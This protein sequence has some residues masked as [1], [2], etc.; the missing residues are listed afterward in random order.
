[1]SPVQ[2]VWPKP[3]L[4]AQCK[5][6]GGEDKADRKKKE[7]GKQHQRMGTDLEFA[8]SVRAVENRETWRKFVVKSSVVPQKTPAVKG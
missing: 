7:M 2:Q 6:G 4:E 3:S 8:K 1:M 5:G